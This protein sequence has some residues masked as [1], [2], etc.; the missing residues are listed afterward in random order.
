M[1][2]E[3]GTDMGRKNSRAIRTRYEREILEQDEIGELRL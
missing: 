2:N 1:N 3:L